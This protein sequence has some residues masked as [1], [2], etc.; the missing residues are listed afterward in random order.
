ME[1]T[2][3]ELFLIQTSPE[4]CYMNFIDIDI[5]TYINNSDVLTAIV[6]T[7]EQFTLAFLHG[8]LDKTNYFQ[9]GFE[10]LLGHAE[11]LG[12]DITKDMFEDTDLSL[13]I[14]NTPWILDLF[15]TQKTT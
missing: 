11:K 6:L 10:I 13:D 15:D 3:E 5:G 8:E 1:R 9:K 2:K 4:R 12:L 7:A 14:F